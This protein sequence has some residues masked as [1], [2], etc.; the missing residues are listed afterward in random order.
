M[1]E[2]LTKRVLNFATNDMQ[3]VGYFHV[4]R[5]LI[6]QNR[7]IT[8]YPKCIHKIKNKINM[9]SENLFFSGL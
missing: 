9:M 8:V 5:K 3:E 6:L 1:A 7:I 2:K 4:Y